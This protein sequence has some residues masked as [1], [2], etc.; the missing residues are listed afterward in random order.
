MGYLYFFF[1]KGRGLCSLHPFGPQ[2]NLETIDFTGPRGQGA[3]G[4]NSPTSKFKEVF[5]VK[6][7][8]H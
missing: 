4:L 5:V 6:L 1:Q 7:Y 8:Y 2:K 3:G